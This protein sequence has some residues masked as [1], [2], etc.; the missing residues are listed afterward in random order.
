MHSDWK[1][2]DKIRAERD[3][4]KIKVTELVQAIQ[5]VS[6]GTISKQEYENLSGQINE[7]EELQA[8]LI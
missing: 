7:M 3:E 8:R 4:Y 1:N 5:K 6:K 2:I